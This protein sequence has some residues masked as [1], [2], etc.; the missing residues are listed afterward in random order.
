MTATTAI[1]PVVAGYDGGYDV[2]YFFECVE[3]SDKDSGWIDT[4]YYAV[5]VA[6]G[7]HY[8]HFKV[9]ARDTSPNNNLT[10][11]SCECYANDQPGCH[12]NPPLCE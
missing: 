5:Q 10:G 11:W 7:S 6:S 8:Y 4:A 1:D 9:R 12:N 2:E 3:D